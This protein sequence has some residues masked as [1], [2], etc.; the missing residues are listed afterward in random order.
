MPSSLQEGSGSF[1][2]FATRVFRAFHLPSDFSIFTSSSWGLSLLYSNV[3]ISETRKITN[4]YL[5]LLLGSSG[6]IGLCLPS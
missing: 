3:K 5:L 6:S 1:A 4:N 2:L